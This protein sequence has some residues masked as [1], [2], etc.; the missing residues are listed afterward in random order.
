VPIDELTGLLARWH[1]ADGRL[2]RAG[3]LREAAETL[4]GLSDADRR[5]LGT[6]LAEQGMEGLAT[7][8]VAGRDLGGDAGHALA[9]DLLALDTDRVLDVLSSLE[10]RAGHLPPPPPSADTATVPSE[11]RPEHPPEPMPEPVPEPQPD[12]QAEPPPEE[13]PVQRPAR[14]EEP[15]APTGSE[16][17]ASEPARTAE[18]H[19]VPPRPQV[20]PPVEARPP[21]GAARRGGFEL[22]QPRDAE[23]ALAQLRALPA[24]WRR[25]RAAVR[26]LEEGVLAGADPATLLGAFERIADRRRVADQLLAVGQVDADRLRDQ[27]PAQAVRRLVRR[28]ARRS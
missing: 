5:A 22:P 25:R 12:L 16:P 28:R 18:R 8:L 21:A 2:A 10:Q 23:D 20:A 6:A 27:L 11:P 24:G 7:P 9:D 17:T 1:A 26:W 3:V 19:P 14:A 13:P 4:R 15:P